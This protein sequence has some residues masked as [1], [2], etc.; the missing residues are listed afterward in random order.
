[1]TCNITKRDAQ[2]LGKELFIDYRVVPFHIW[3]KGLK[4]ECEHWVSAHKD[5]FTI[6]L[7]T[8]DHLLEFPDYYQRL[9]RMEKQAHKYW[10]RRKKPSVLK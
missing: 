2:R 10:S 8:L 3:W 6:A 4:I 7:I 5:K 1:M 9:I